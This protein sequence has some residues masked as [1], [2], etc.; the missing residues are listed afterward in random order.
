MTDPQVGQITEGDKTFIW[1]AEERRGEERGSEVRDRTR[2]K[3][4]T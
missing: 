2:G 1:P 3:P 4:T